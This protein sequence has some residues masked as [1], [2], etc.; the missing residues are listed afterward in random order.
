MAGSFPTIKAPKST[1]NRDIKYIDNCRGSSVVERGPEK[2]GVGGPI[3][4]LGIK[5]KADH[6]VC[7]NFIP[8]SVAKLSMIILQQAASREFLTG[9]PC[10]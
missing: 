10:T 2:A 6:T 4:S 8:T 9:P 3:P 1:S 5:I 7:L